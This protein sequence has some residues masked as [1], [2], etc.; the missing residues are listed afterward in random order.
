MAHPSTPNRLGSS[1]PQVVPSTLSVTVNSAEISGCACRLENLVEQI[2]DRI[3]GAYPRAI[4]EA[5]SPMGLSAE[6]EATR[7]RLSALEERLQRVLDS[8]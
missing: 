4:D 5:S 7:R 1:S 6:M 2:E 3:N 8:I